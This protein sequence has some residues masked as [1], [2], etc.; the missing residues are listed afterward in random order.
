[1]TRRK[2]LDADKIEEIEANFNGIHFVS[3]EMRFVFHKNVIPIL[4]MLFQYKII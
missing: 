4:S 2:S 1:M 3:T